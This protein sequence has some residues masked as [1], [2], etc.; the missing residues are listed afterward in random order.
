M[1]VYFCG[2]MPGTRAGHF[3]KPYDG[4]HSPWGEPPGAS[5][6][7]RASG[8]PL[9]DWHPERDGERA[10]RPDYLQRERPTETEGEFAHLIVD[11]WT[12]I[13]AWDRSADTRP[14]CSASFAVHVE[15]DM[16]AMLALARLSWPAV[17][18]RIE[19]HIGRRAGVRPA[20]LP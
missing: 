15:M 2:V 6:G 18:E 4:E 7:N 11:G 12:L 16:G 19:A 17:F 9:M 3:C 8:Y 5:S 14:G 13:A 1:T 10:P 20:V